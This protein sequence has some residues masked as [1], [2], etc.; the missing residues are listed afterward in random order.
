MFLPNSLRRFF[1]DPGE[2]HPHHIT[3]TPQA[4]LVSTAGG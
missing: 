1:A 2:I 3:V 4:G